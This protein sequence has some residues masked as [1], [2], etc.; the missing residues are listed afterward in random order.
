LHKSSADK[1]FLQHVSGNTHKSC[2]AFLFGQKKHHCLFVCLQPYYGISRDLSHS[3]YA[4]E[5]K[6]DACRHICKEFNRTSR[7]QLSIQVVRRGKMTRER[8][9][10]RERDLAYRELG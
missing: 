6:D 4:K 7:D 3:N 9:R 2:K 1:N 8:E 10:E 5:L